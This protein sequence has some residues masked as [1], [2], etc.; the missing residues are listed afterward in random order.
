MEHSGNYDC[1][2]YYKG[3]ELEQFIVARRLDQVVLVAVGMRLNQS[4]GL[5]V[6]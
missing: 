5:G 1:I 6:C 3:E 4:I 2:W